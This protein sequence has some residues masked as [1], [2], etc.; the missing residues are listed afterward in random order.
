MGQREP[1]HEEQALELV[2]Q[3]IDLLWQQQVGL[4]TGRHEGSEAGGS[5]CSGVD[6]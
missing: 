4:S 5:L 2:W 6:G 1:S 3:A